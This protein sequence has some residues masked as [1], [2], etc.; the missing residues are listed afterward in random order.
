[1][2]HESPV[3]DK[4]TAGA[5]DTKAVRQ[6]LAFDKAAYKAAF[7]D[8][9]YHVAVTTLFVKYAQLVAQQTGH[10]HCK[11]PMTVNEAEEVGAL[12][13]EFVL[14]FQVPILGKWYSTKIHKLV[15]HIVE[16][17][18]RHGAVMNGDTSCN[19]ALHVHD[20]RRYCRTS[21]DDDI[22]RPQLLRVGQ[23][24]L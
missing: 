17:I 6:G 19:E 15:A 1:M 11:L 7:G 21:G 13:K 24:V 20:K 3:G 5:A 10:R 22:F 4:T 8:M 2:Q 12:A 9:P 23:G 16:A 18:Q 14:R